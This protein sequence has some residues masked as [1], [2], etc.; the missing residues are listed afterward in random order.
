MLSAIYSRKT[1]SLIVW[2]GVVNFIIEEIPQF[3]IQVIITIYLWKSN[4]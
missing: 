2:F 1:K 4:K 3:T